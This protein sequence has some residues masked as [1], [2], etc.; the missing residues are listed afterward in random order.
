[1]KKDYLMSMAVSASQASRDPSTKVGCIIARPDGSIASAGYNGF[2][3]KS[4]DRFMSYTKPM[5]YLLIIHAE[6]NAINQCRDFD[7]S[8]YVMYITHAPCHD[9]LKQ[10]LNR[11]IREIYYKSSELAK[12]ATVDGNEAIVRMI[13]A[14]NAIVQNEVTG[15]SYVKEL[16]EIH[17][18][19]MVNELMKLGQD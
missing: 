13:L 14:T 15:D 17:G 19:E 10:A 12:R 5:K 9:C 1:M 4:D 7:L 18:W 6:V 2:I 16:A 3:R 8:G 11:G